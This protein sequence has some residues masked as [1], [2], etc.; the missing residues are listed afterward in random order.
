MKTQGPYWN[1]PDRDRRENTHRNNNQNESGRYYNDHTSYSGYEHDAQNMRDADDER[2]YY[3][4][5]Y[6][7]PRNYRD[8]Q[9]NG[10][11][12]YRR[13]DERFIDPRNNN[14]MN[15]NYRENMNNMHDPRNNY[16]RPYDNRNNYNNTQNAPR[17]NETPWAFDRLAQRIEH[18]WNRWVNHDYHGHTP[19]SDFSW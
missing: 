10:P 6:D 2:N 15:N 11:N 9:D 8:E 19:D 1:A 16:E 12:G 7:E 18:G 17:N 14:N 4:N 13:N 3:S 5:Q